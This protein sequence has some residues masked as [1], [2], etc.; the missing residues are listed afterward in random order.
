VLKPNV[1]QWKKSLFFLSILFLKDK[2]SLSLMN[3]LR[4]E[5]G[6]LLESLQILKKKKNILCEK[7]LSH[8][9]TNSPLIVQRGVEYK[10]QQDSSVDRKYQN[11]CQSPYTVITCR[12][13]DNCQCSGRKSIPAQYKELETSQESPGFL[14]RKPTLLSSPH[15]NAT[16][17]PATVI[18][19]KG[20]L[21]MSS[22]IVEGLQK[23]Y[24]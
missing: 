12:K 6:L 1:I 11:K 19:M 16:T 20:G 15:M 22:G 7:S 2:G 13:D 24:N 18:L 4:M 9:M 17:Q 5:K 21:P 3:L 10:M 23:A 14:P 8:H